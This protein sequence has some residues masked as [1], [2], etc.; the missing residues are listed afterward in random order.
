[1]PIREPDLKIVLTGG[2]YGYTRD[3]GVHVIPLTCFR[4]LIIAEYPTI[5]PS[6]GTC[7][8]LKT[9]VCCEK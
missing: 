8:P 9:G 5:Y 1:M 2:Q 4:D 6:S 7:F 3:D